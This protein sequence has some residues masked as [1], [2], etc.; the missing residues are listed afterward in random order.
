MRNH[1]T[2]HHTTPQK[3]EIDIHNMTR[4]QAKRH[5]ELYLSRADGSVKEVS[6]IHGYTGGTVLRDMVRNSLRH[7]RIRAKYAT[8]NP[9]VTVLVLT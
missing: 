1:N 5:L 4:D 2:V 7:P 3:A 8:L 6:V 9:G